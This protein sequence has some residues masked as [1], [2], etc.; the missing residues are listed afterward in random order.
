ME[1]GKEGGGGCSRIW[2]GGSVGWD[3][4]SGVVEGRGRGRGGKAVCEMDEGKGGM[5]LWRVV[6]AG[7][8]G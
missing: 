5:A 7:E 8:L 3:W 4:V 2:W 6:K 1:S